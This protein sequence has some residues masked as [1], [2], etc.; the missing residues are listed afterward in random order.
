[1]KEISVGDIDELL[2]DKTIV[3]NTKFRA[4][5]KQGFWEVDYLVN[6]IVNI[7]DELRA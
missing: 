2:K 7:P 1:M 4:N 5:I 3:F 6:K